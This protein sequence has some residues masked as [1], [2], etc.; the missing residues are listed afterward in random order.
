MR[1][2]LMHCNLLFALRNTTK[3]ITIEDKCLVNNLTP[4]RRSQHTHTIVLLL[5]R[6]IDTGPPLKE[7]VVCKL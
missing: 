3:A 4:V 6:M 5:R 7:T 1:I 2:I